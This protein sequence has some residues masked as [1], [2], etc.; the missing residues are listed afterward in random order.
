[1][2]VR[3]GPG[4]FVVHTA[5]EIAL[6]RGGEVAEAAFFRLQPGVTAIDDAKAI[7]D[8]SAGKKRGGTGTGEK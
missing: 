5:H 3:E 7:P 8:A 6:A 2:R 1:M 4:P